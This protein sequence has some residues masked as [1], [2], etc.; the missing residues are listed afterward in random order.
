MGGADEAEPRKNG[1]GE[2]SMSLQVEDDPKIEAELRI[3]K[4]A[5]AKEVRDRLSRT[6]VMQEETKAYLEMVRKDP[7]TE[8]QLIKQTENLRKYANHPGP[9]AKEDCI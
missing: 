6:P 5:L 8:E 9:W 1:N 7:M 3:H 2:E 4:S